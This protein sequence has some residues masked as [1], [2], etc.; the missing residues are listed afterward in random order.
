M[1]LSLIYCLKLLAVL[2]LNTTCG[3]L[4]RLEMSPCSNPGVKDF[5]SSGNVLVEED[6]SLRYYAG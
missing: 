3:S 4:S 2:C 5:D 1:M 6:L